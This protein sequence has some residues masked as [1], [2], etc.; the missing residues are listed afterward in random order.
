MN[1]SVFR[2]NINYLSSLGRYNTERRPVLRQYF[3]HLLGGDDINQ[4]KIDI[5]DV[6]QFAAQKKPA[7]EEGDL[8]F[9]EIFQEILLTLPEDINPQDYQ[10]YLLFRY[11][12]LEQALEEKGEFAVYDFLSFE[13]LLRDRIL[14]ETGLILSDLHLFEDKVPCF[15][16]E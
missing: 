13:A 7:I 10:G 5:D 11:S 14:E 6:R 16:A 9:D 8:G 15:A 2:D 12:H 1:S 4:R 3:N